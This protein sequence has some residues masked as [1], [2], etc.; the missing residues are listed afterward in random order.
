MKTS[1]TSNK[2]QFP[3]KRTMKRH[4]ILSLGAFAA[5]LLGVSASGITVDFVENSEGQNVTINYSSADWWVVS[6]PTTSVGPESA[7][8]SGYLPP[9]ANL[10]SG[11]YVVG[12]QESPGGPP[13]D[14]LQVSWNSVLYLGTFY[15]T[16]FNF[17]FQSDT[18]GQ[19]LQPPPGDHTIALETGDLQR[20]HI[21]STAFNLNIGI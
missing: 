14:W 12:L 4:N 1:I 6:P 13:S 5:G 15:L 17:T 20:F 3:L 16:Q 2:N 18:E 8:F 10:G 21:S 19:T 7:T 11:S 9:G